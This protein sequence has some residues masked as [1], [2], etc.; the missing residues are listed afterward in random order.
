MSHLPCRED[1]SAGVLVL[2]LEC[3][4]HYVIIKQYLNIQELMEEVQ[5]TDFHL[6]SFDQSGH[7]HLVYIKTLALACFGMSPWQL[8][9]QTRISFQDWLFMLSAAPRHSAVG[10][11]RWFGRPYVIQSHRSPSPQ[12]QT[13]PDFEVAPLHAML[14]VSQTWGHCFSTPVDRVR[15]CEGQ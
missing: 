11:F 2:F 4:S 10:H 12:K 15:E 13:S 3:L 6:Q 9:I 7:G 14:P 1:S 5:G 8:C